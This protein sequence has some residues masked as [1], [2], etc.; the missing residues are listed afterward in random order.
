MGLR[1]ALERGFPDL[2]AHRLAL[3]LEVVANC[4]TQARVLQ[5]VRAVRDG[6]LEAARDLVLAARARLEAGEAAADALLDAEVE[7]DVEVEERHV[8]RGAPVATEE[9]VLPEQVEGA[10]QARSRLRSRAT[11]KCR[12]SGMVEKISSKKARFR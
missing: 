12:R 10:A 4:R 8:R 5:V 9:R 1:P 3:A 2:L 6:R 7:A 11:T